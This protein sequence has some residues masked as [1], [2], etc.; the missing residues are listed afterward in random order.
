MI[1]QLR[2]PSTHRLRLATVG[3]SE[4]TF[5]SLRMCLYLILRS[6]AHNRCCLKRPPAVSIYTARSGALL[7]SSLVPLVPL[8]HCTACISSSC[9]GPVASTSSTSRDIS[10]LRKKTTRRGTQAGDDVVQEQQQ[11]HN[12]LA[13]F[14]D[15]NCK[16]MEQRCSD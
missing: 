14:Y 5:W 16:W 13:C 12:V 9:T 7:V 2:D 8:V 6:S 3:G 11:N 4:S 10:S 15:I 1:Q